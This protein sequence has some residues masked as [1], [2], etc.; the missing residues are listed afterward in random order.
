MGTK[1]VS[2]VN[3]E[4]IAEHDVNAIIARRLAGEPFGA[5]NT[6]IPLREPGRW[7]TYEANSMADRNMHYRMV[8]EL[9]WIPLR[10]EDL[11]EGLSPESIGWQVGD[12][13]Q[14][15]RGTQ[16]D[17]RLYKMP[18]DVR[19]QISDAKARANMRGMGSAKA[20]KASVME[21]AS[22]QLGDEAAAFTSAAITVTG[23]DRVT[24]GV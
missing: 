17:Q 9:G 24:G 11:P 4:D 13:G 12:G 21:A 15:V 6:T 14:L 7:A 5:R 3:R 2:V 19:K 22:A 10:I 8:H 23:Q 20:V 16:G 18:A 1:T